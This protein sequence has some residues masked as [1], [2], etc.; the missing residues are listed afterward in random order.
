MQAV[1]G[2][3]YMEFGLVNGQEFITKATEKSVE[4]CL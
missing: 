2:L 3:D 4:H 1:H